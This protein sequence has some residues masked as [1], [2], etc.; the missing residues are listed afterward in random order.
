MKRI[1]LNGTDTLVL[2]D[3]IVPPKLARLFASRRAGVTRRDA[4]ALVRESAPAIPHQEVKAIEEP[5]CL[6]K[7]SLAETERPTPLLL[8][9]AYAVFGTSVAGGVGYAIYSVHGLFHA[10]AL[11]HAVRAFLR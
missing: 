2:S 5:F 1:H 7:A 11:D 3:V 9:I 6:W 10:D 8:R 4:P